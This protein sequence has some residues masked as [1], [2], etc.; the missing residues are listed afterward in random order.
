MIRQQ[1][2]VI[3]RSRCDSCG[4]PSDNPDVAE[5]V[6]IGI[7][8]IKEALQKVTLCHPCIEHELIPAVAPWALT[9]I[10]HHQHTGPG[11]TA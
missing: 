7:G 5:L 8:I 4:G 11:P 2:T 9:G 1:T 6:T 10:A 3:E